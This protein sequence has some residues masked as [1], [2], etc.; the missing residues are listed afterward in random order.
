MWHEDVAGKTALVS[1][2]PLASRV[3]SSSQQCPSAT[4]A[5]VGALWERRGKVSFKGIPDNLVESVFSRDDG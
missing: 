4:G 5:L 2:Q 1:L 3:R